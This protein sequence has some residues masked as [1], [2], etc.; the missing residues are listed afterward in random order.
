MK[1]SDDTIRNRTRYLPTCSTVLKPTA[2]P[3]D[4]FVRANLKLD[5]INYFLGSQLVKWLLNTEMF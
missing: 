4:K 5:K 2:P 3:R 1:N